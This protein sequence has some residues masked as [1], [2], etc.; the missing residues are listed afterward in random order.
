M[1]KTKDKIRSLSFT[2]FCALLVIVGLIVVASTHHVFLSLGLFGLPETSLDI[3]GWV[4]LSQSFLLS[5]LLV[6]IALIF[7]KISRTETPF[8][9]AI[10]HRMKIAAL[11]LFCVLAVPRWI[12]DVA[13]SISTDTFSF[14]LFGESEMFALAIAA[15]VYCM[16]QI[17]DY[18][19]M[20]QD[21]SYEII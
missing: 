13:F 6:Y 7:K 12:G 8:T 9:K 16:A 10:P 18:G 17:F 11:G 5:A 21:E 2:L 19:F 15:I 3:A 1:E 20:L 14:V 4:I